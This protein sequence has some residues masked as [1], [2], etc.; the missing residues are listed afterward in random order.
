LLLREGIMEVA[1]LKGYGRSWTDAMT[2]MPDEVQRKI[3]KSSQKII[4]KHLG[5]WNLL[6]FPFLFSREQKR[7]SKID[8]SHVRERGLDNEAFI[9]SQI[10]FNALYSLVSRLIGRE[11][12][13]EVFKEIMEA[14]AVD[15]FESIWPSPEDFAGFDD[16]WAA[17]REYTRATAEADNRDGGHFFEIVEDT[18]EA[19]QMNV[20]YCAWYEIACAHGV[21]EACLASCYSDDIGMPAVGIRFQRTK[22]I[23]SGGDCC[24]FRFLRPLD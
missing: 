9:Q 1:D 11:R 16:P 5:L 4:T 20:T 2:G 8:L 22:T 19:I 15:V 10:E 7:M 17:F 3:R 24:D 21:K 23:A 12:T 14:T 13:R 6:K 18:E